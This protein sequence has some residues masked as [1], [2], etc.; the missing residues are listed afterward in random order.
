MRTGFSSKA[1]VSFASVFVLLVCAYLQ[2]A[3]SNNKVRFER[4]DSELGLSQNT[5][6][7]IIQDRNGFMWFGTQ[8]GLNRFDGY[9]FKTY[10]HD[11]QNRGRLSDNWIETIFEDLSGNLWIGTRRGGLNL[12]NPVSESF[13]YFRYDTTNTRTI[14]SDYILAFFES[15]RGEL[16]L[17]ASNGLNRFE[18][19]TGEFTRFYYA[20]SDSNNAAH[21]WVDV[22]YED[23]DGVLWVGT[24]K[25]LKQFDRAAEVLRPFQSS[26][27]LLNQAW[28]TEIVEEPAAGEK[29]LWVGTRSGLFR[30]DQKNDNIRHFK[31]VAGDPNSLGSDNI[32]C[33]YLDQ[34]R[35]LWI[36]TQGGGLDRFD[37][38]S[39][40]F[41]HHQHDPKDPQSLSVN[42]VFS[43]AQDR[44]GGMWIGTRAGLNRFE[45]EPF[46]FQHVQKD[47]E[48]PRSLSDNAIWAFHE[49]GDGAIWVG[50]LTGGLN[51][52]DQN[53]NFQ[54]QYRRSAQTGRG[55][56]DNS[57]WAVFEDR[58][59]T[60]W[61]GTRNGGLNQLDR[62]TGNFQNF[63]RLGNNANS[64]SHNWVTSIHEREAE[65]GVLWLGTWGGGLNRFEP[66][67]GRFKH[68]RHDAANSKSLGSDGV[69]II[70]ESLVENGRILWLGTEAGL[71]KFDPATEE[72]TRFKHD[73]ADDRSLSNNSVWSI[74]ETP[75]GVLWVGTNSGLNRFDRES[76]AFTR[77][78]KKDG[79]PNEVIYGVLG[80]DHG[81]LW[82]STNL[83]IIKFNPETGE[84]KNYQARDGLQS[85]EFN[86]NACLLTRSGKMY[87]GGINGFNVFSPDSI[88]DNHHVPP[89]QITGLK[90]YNSDI[91][92]GT[93][94]D[95]KGVAY[96]DEITLSY[97]DEILTF[98]FAA[99]NYRKTFKN[100]YAFKL[101]GLNENWIQLGTE[102]RATFTS[103]SPGSYTLNV[104]G[105]NDDGVWNE[106]G[107]KLTLIITPP[108]W[109]T[110]WAYAFYLL[111]FISAIWGYIR[112]RTQAQ[113]R[114]LS[115]KRRELEQEQKVTAELRRVDKLKDEFLANTSHELRTPL[116]GI[117]GVT[118]SLIDSFEDDPPVKTRSNL[119]MVASSGRRLTALVND[120][121]DFSKLKSHDLQIDKRPVDIRV[122]TDVVMKLSEPLTKG[123]SVALKNEIPADIPAADGDENRLQQILHNLVGNAI[124]FTHEGS[125]VVSAIQKNGRVEVAVK[126]TGIG[127]PEDKFETIFKFFEQADASTARA[128][129][130]TGLGLA[131]TKQLV[132][133]H[134]GEIWL[135][136][137]IGEGSTFSF[138]IP[139]SVGNAAP[140]TESRL[141]RVRDAGE[142]LAHDDLAKLEKQ[143]LLANEHGDF[144]ILLVD[145]EP[146]NQLVLA[147]HLSQTNYAFTHAADGEEALKLI[148]SGKRFDLVLL[149]VMMPR[150]SGYE[151][152]QKIR[153]KHLASEMPVI[154]VTAKDQVQDLLE[155]LASG[156]NDYL[157]KP[158]SKDEL[159]ARIKT[160]LNLL[161]IN[162]AM[163]KF[164]PHE[165]LR[166]LQKE[167]I[168][169][170]KLG[171]HVEMDVAIFVSDV[172]RFTT[173]SEK[174]TPTENFNFINAYFSLVSPLIRKNHGFVDRY[175]GDAIMAIFPRSVDDA[176]QSS[177]E[178]LRQLQEFN[179]VREKKSQQPI[180]IGVGL[181]SG[182][183]MLGIV[184]EEERLQ[185]DIFSDAVNLT[186]RIEGLC[187]QYGVSI[188]ISEAASRELK[189]R[190]SYH[191]RFLGKIQVVGKDDFVSLY[192]VY[193]GDPDD[194]LALKLKT[195]EDFEN[196]LASYF[197]KEFARAVV[198]FENVLKI[199]PKDKAAK[200]YL[201]RAAQY[202]VKG[203]PEDWQGVEQVNTK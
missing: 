51:K 199:S 100:Q 109:R 115:F 189:D 154:M 16:W 191:T 136:S 96:R 84:I 24:E 55:L 11:S 107:A 14:S 52:F 162:S 111:L 26:S 110:M 128:F 20:A 201:E 103:L 203:V 82:L 169:D 142:L 90:R 77:F 5:I 74:Y 101:D 1:L 18:P 124:K 185:G 46:P 35:T 117:L 62:S 13:S 180:E 120:I 63:Q 29:I 32:R 94:I 28:I 65:P 40:K 98:E 132:E 121:L 170:V 85:N 105:S 135:E 67:T 112:F 193:D 160:H 197:V 83:G 152:C 144:S 177:L 50:T 147:N 15:K 61:I 104:R 47:P 114:E 97:K 125:V 153:R 91:A 57:V 10:T 60:L 157:A 88:R 89:I 202:V 17:G 92:E 150:M 118:E 93:A 87:F 75:D 12:F 2:P 188:I 44:S 122:L 34:E 59:G 182:G 108:W 45:H 48:N 139:V 39:E 116:N 151:V 30:I 138:S 167:S 175:T 166:Y 179:K 163:G 134:G 145:D 38:D 176:L 102:R 195:K 71:N 172:R 69:W 155:G 173:I 41:T 140:T 8:E 79:L 49:D 36:G 156:A 72:F 7:S 127:V 196:G 137:K 21:N 164:V 187:K 119:R 27:P 9:A 171:D 158:F 80:D 6:Q 194:V 25:G 148:D 64:L 113:A 184:G 149:D 190:D 4:F 159:L 198:S 181:H 161:K 143:F 58:A 186:N 22:I 95:E 31:H 86:A 78:R 126:D 133:L 81:N 19:G 192:E 129:G 70:H 178:T 56:N 33:M 131:V 43:I 141:A 130:G 3:L 42:D 76:G 53:A 123:K 183:L 23:R 200:L 146:I 37:L 54:E 99:L 165:F 174:M 66:K 68:F 73:P 106:D 168:V